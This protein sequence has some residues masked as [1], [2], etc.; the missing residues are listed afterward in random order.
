V[1]GA[2]RVG[3]HAALP[4]IRDAAGHEVG[5]AALMLTLRYVLATQ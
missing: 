5:D 1:L 4:E 2:F 3:T